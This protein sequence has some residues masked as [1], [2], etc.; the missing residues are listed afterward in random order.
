MKQTTIF[1][2][3]YP[4]YKIS[5]PIRLIELFAGYGSQ[6][7]ALK[8]LGVEFE[9]YKTCEWAIK[10]IQAY[11][12]IHIEDDTDYSKGLSKD[13]LAKKL[14]NY[15]VS[16]NYNE[17]ANHSLLLRKKEKE[18]R[19]IYN[20]I[21][22]NNNLVNIQNVKGQDLEIKD[23][24]KYE[25]IM[26]YSFPCQDLSLAG[27]RQGMAD[28]S[29]R[30][31]MLWEVERILKECEEKPQ[32][33]LMENVPEVIGIANIEHFNKWQYELEKMGYKNYV[34]TLIATDYGIPQ[35]RNRTFMVSVLGDYSYMFPKKIPLKLK[36]KDMLEDEVDEKYY[37]SDKLIN[38]IALTAKDTKNYISYARYNG[39]LESLCRVWKEKSP[40]L[41]TKSNEIKILIPEATKKGYA[42]ATEG[43]GVYI[44]RPQQKR[45]VVQKEKIQTLKTGQDV[46]VVVGTYQYSKSE[47]FMQGKSRFKEG[48]EVADTLQTTDKEGIVYSNLRIRKLTPKEVFRLMGVKDKDF[49][50]VSKNQSNSSLYHLA[51]DSIV[52]TVLMGIFGELLNMD[53]LGEI[54]KLTKKQKK[55][56]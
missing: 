2:I 40:T 15:G 43:D 12:D 53:Y 10:S 30:S 3:M 45:G 56:I 36:L 23:T 48:K 24:D 28:T 4:K 50:K 34:D 26:T 22:A 9:H 52:T 14:Y 41:H 19:I 35:T 21:I 32:I 55:N 11:K 25:Y 29:T 16:M 27:K 1:D 33:L 7:L 49:E 42:E 54:E 17:P 8:Y 5:K 46:E 44:N 47:N 18:L 13:M 39:Q 6:A 31:G 38:H 51:G 20:N 37:L